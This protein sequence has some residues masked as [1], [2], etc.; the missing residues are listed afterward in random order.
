MN[1]A[2]TAR[3]FK[4]Q[5]QGCAINIQKNVI[6]YKYFCKVIA[7]YWAESKTHFNNFFQ[8]RT[9]FHLRPL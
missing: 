3:H 8:N 1:H 5:M 6:I 7:L 9:V 2:L 4:V